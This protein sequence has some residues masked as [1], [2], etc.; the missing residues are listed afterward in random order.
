ML[1]HRIVG[2]AQSLDVATDQVPFAEEVTG[3]LMHCL[4][5]AVLAVSLV[6]CPCGDYRQFMVEGFLEFRYQ[7]HLGDVMA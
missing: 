7:Q 6:D 3:V 4:G 1:F 2:G 5:D